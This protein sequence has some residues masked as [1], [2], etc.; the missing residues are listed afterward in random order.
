M[1]RVLLCMCSR[2]SEMC[3]RS[4]AK[5][6]GPQSSLLPTVRGGEPL[7]QPPA[8]PE[9]AP[10]AATGL[11]EVHRRAAVPPLDPKGEVLKNSA[12]SSAGARIYSLKSSGFCKC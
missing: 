10:T 6:L 3:L 1:S 7:C 2:D 4:Q 5:A 12:G 8:P 9:G 11:R